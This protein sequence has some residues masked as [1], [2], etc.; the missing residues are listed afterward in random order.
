MDSGTFASS[1]ATLAKLGFEE[2]ELD[3]TVAADLAVLKGSEMGMERKT[4]HLTAATTVT[5]RLQG[6]QKTKQ[7]ISIKK[8]KSWRTKKVASSLA[9]SS[10]FAGP[11][12]SPRNKGRNQKEWGG[13]AI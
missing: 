12:E 11:G 7:F 5:A 9:R 2:A 1:L 4:V 6:K 8:S 3:A 10:S 13:L